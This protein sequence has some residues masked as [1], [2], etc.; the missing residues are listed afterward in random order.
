LRQSEKLGSAFG[1]DDARGLQK[2]NQSLPREL[3]MGRRSVDEV[4]A[5]PTAK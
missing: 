1:G 3:R 5:E 4:E 2:K